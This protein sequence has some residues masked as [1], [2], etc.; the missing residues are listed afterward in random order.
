MLFFELFEGNSPKKAQSRRRSK[1]ETFF[2]Q[3]KW[4]EGPKGSLWGAKVVPKSAQNLQKNF[5]SRRVCFFLL[6]IF[7]LFKGKSTNFGENV[8]ID[9]KFIF[10]AQCFFFAVFGSQAKKYQNFNFFCLNSAQMHMSR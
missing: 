8:C 3:K 10:V 4:I 2:E 5:T 1:R 6:K 7:E 9:E